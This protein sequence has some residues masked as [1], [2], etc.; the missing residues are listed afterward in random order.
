[1]I[2]VETWVSAAGGQA[3]AANFTEAMGDAM[4]REFV[5]G[6]VVHAACRP[7]D[8]AFWRVDEKISGLLVSLQAF[9]VK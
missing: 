6:H 4:R 7:C 3:G 9:F 8:L 5:S 2:R 1:M